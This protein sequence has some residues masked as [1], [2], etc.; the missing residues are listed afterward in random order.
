MK[1]AKGLTPSV[2]FIQQAQRFCEAYLNSCGLFHQMSASN[3][4]I[5]LLLAYIYTA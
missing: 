1:G 3:E 4:A 2:P 5:L